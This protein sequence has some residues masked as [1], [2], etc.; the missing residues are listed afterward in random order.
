VICD[1]TIY[2]PVG[3]ELVC[4]VKEWN[5]P[6][7]KTADVLPPRRVIMYGQ[8]ALIPNNPANVLGLVESVLGQHTNLGANQ[9]N[10]VKWFHYDPVPF[11]L[12]QLHN[13]RFTELLCTYCTHDV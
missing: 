12:C 13:P 7:Y 1:I 8:P 3:D 9:V 4:Y 11:L 2:K 10:K 6:S 5:Y